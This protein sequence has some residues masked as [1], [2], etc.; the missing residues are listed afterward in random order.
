LS[1]L[2]FLYSRKT[3]KRYPGGEETEKGC[4]LAKEKENKHTIR[5]S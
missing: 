2:T 3:Q 5:I 4:P 1:P